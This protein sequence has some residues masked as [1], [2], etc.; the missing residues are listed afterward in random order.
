M[1]DTFT[2]VLGY[3]VKYVDV[4]PV[5]YSKTLVGYGWPK[6]QAD[7][8]VELML[9]IKAGKCD[10]WS[11]DIKN[12]TGQHTSLDQ[13]ITNNK[14]TFQKAPGS[15]VT[16]AFIKPD[17]VAA[18]KA[19][20]MLAKIKAAGYACCLRASLLVGQGSRS[21]SSA[22]QQIRCGRTKANHTS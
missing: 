12:V 16:F 2:K 13:W 11:P 10:A 5:E 22:T 14:A 15:Q 21:C 8:L 20:E 6:W 19:D 1:A 18:G 4:D 9:L 17:V 7:G 3:P